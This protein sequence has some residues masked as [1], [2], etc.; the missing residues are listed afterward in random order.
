M[1]ETRA[2]SGVAAAPPG[3]MEMTPAERRAAHE[4]IYSIFE[5]YELKVHGLVPLAIWKIREA[6]H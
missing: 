2:A 1:C 6:G 3:D 5:L 4:V